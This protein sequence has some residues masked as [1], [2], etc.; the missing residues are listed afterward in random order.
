MNQLPA[1]YNFRFKPFALS[2]MTVIKW[3][4]SYC[5]IKNS[6]MTAK[7]ES[8]AGNLKALEV[9]WRNCFF[10]LKYWDFPMEKLSLRSGRAAHS[11]QLTCAGQGSLGILKSEEG[12]VS[13][14][15]NSCSTK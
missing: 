4:V 6:N 8:K 7:L 5:V 9:T 15:L 10:F 1:W 12:C 3:R 2:L 11:N 13:E 14:A